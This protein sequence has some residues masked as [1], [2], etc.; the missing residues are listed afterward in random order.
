MN[1]LGYL[2]G[3]ALALAAGTFA[4]RLAGPALGSRIALSARTT[5]LLENSS[6]VVLAALVLTTGL[7]EDAAPA[8]FARPAGVLVAGVLCRFR[9][10]LPLVL[11]AAAATTAALR[12]AGVP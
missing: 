8:G 5:Q 1:H 11:V 6:V 4:L 7:T 12:L 2:V 10:P 3:A 9:M